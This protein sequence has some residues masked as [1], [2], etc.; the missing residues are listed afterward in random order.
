MSQQEYEPLSK[1][2]VSYVRQ[3]IIDALL[4]YCERNQ[5]GRDVVV[6]TALDAY[7][8]GQVSHELEHLHSVIEMQQAE[9]E[10]LL[11]THDEL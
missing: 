2:L 3:S 7:L 1:S 6:D 8:R 11:Q 5:R 4:A 10:R 9:I